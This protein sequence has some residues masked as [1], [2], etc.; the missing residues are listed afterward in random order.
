ML[1]PLQDILIVLLILIIFFL[2]IK[3][4][5]KCKESYTELEDTMNI[6]QS[7]KALNEC[8]FS[9]DC[10]PSIYSNEKGCMCMDKK[11]EEILKTRGYN[12]TTT[13]GFDY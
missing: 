11:Q 2:F 4:E 8:R 6:N 7:Q 10:C 5:R 13:D 3:S 1:P 9:L 12:K